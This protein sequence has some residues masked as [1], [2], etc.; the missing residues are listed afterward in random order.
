MRKM[1]I[2]LSALTLSASIACT[3]FGTETSGSLWNGD[4]LY[5]FGT[6]NGTTYENEMLGYGVELPSDWKFSDE[7]TIAE[8]NQFGEDFLPE[9]MAEQIKG[10]GIIIDMSAANSLDTQNINVQFHNIPISYGEGLANMITPEVLINLLMLDL[11]TTL[12]T[13]GYVDPTV[14]K[15]EYTISGDQIAGVK[16][17]G[18]VLG[19]DVYQDMLVIKANDQYIAMITITS[20]GEDNGDE[21]ISRFYRL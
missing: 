10:M 8:L 1:R 4:N 19:L 21:I 12:E 3:C 11:G 15:T 14:E 6:V 16:V 7:E 18:K 13:A 5:K 17:T 9:E 20:F 2:I